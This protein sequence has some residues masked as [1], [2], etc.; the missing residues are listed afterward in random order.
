MPQT[1]KA[2]VRERILE[3]ATALLYQ[4][5]PDGATMREIAKAAG[6][7]P[8]NLYRYY[9]GKEQLLAAITQPVL[10]GLDALV[11][12]HTDRLVALGQPGPRLPLPAGMLGAGQLKAQL[13][14]RLTPA[15]EDLCRLEEAYPRPMR[16]LCQADTVSGAL[17]GWFYALVRETLAQ[18]L[19]PGCL[20]EG[21]LEPLVQIEGQSF[22]QGVVELLGRHHELDDARRA[23]LIR[24]Y[25]TVHLEGLAALLNAGFAS[26]VILPREET[27]H[28]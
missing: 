13:Y 22:C 4:K 2:P 24:C 3:A 6:V 20:D 18:L 8:G 12:R 15:L 14:A 16:I 11:Q 5:G 23:L 25:L 21:L 9:P 1:L 17:L 10:E 26:G 27:H 19:Q 7:T 28:D